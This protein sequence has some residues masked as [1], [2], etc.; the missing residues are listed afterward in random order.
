MSHCHMTSVS[1]MTLQQ[2]QVQVLSRRLGHESRKRHE[3][4]IS[5]TGL[6]DQAAVQERH[7]LC[8]TLVEDKTVRRRVGWG[9]ET[10][11]EEYYLRVKTTNTEPLHQHQMLPITFSTA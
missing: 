9:T 6:T 7:G 4:S 8:G 1:C 3:R 11:T 10:E 2:G 5:S